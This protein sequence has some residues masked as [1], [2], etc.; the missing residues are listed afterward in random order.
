MTTCH[1]HRR[2]HTHTHTHTHTYMKIPL[3]RISCFIVVSNNK[4][5]KKKTRS[6]PRLPLLVVQIYEQLHMIKFG[7]LCL[8]T[9]TYAWLVSFLAFFWI[10]YFP[11]QTLFFFDIYTSSWH[12]YYYRR[13]CIVVQGG[14][15]TVG[16]VEK[17]ITWQRVP[18]G[19]C[20]PRQDSCLFGHCGMG[21]ACTQGSQG[22]FGAFLHC[23]NCD[24]TF[25]RFLVFNASWQVL[26][27]RKKTGWKSSP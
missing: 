7:S 21:P 1:P 4:Y 6:C 15:R 24:N 16:K 2:A 14:T 12:I 9:N 18:I 23:D 25:S 26:D 10:I 20:G 11:V 13:G 27:T 17:D 22:V 5:Q 3:G 19:M 8:H